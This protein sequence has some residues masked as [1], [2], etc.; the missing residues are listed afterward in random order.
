MVRS[1]VAM[2]AGGS[3]RVSSSR[4]A[5]VAVLVAGLAVLVVAGR[6]LPT[7]PSAHRPATSTSA[8]VTAGTV[9][10]IPL[11]DVPTSIVVGGVRVP[12][13]I[14]HTLARATSLMRAG[15]L[16]GAAFERDPQIGTAVVVAQE[17]YAGALVPPGSGVGF[18]T[19]TDVQA[20]GS[21]RR[22]RLGRG[23]T[24]WG[25]Q[26]VA[27]DPPRQR[28]TVVVVMPPAVE[29]Q[30]WL[31]T[32]VGRRV[33][34]LDT[35]SGTAPCQPTGGRFRCVVGVGALDGED[36]GVWTATIAKQSAAPAA[37]QVTVTFVTR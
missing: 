28:L 2:H 8:G 1:T 32:V 18:R 12:N 35:N 17:P 29:L 13:A 21:P 37:I 14:G 30:V 22:L 25:Y 26:L 3:M 6:L 10:V 23:P 34:I 16:Q 4:A 36:P 7:I 27:P 19:R 24:S 5:T 20:N 9:R 33:P 11:R 15:G 31:A